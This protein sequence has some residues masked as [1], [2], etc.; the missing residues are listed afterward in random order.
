MADETLTFTLEKVTVTSITRATTLATLTVDPSAHNFSTG[1]YVLV[2]G[3]NQAPYN[4]IFQITVTGAKT[5]TYVMASDPGA[6]ASG[7]LL[8]SRFSPVRQM[9][10]KNDFFN[11]SLTG[12]FVATVALRRSLDEGTTWGNADTY[13]TAAEKVVEDP[14]SRVI[15]HIGFS[16]WTSGSAK[17]IMD[18]RAGSFET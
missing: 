4:G 10:N 6:S 9:K 3:A 18:I 8:T 16:A 7:T 1:D 11:L 14:S 15:Y 2:A 5:F 17:A 13:T 12:T